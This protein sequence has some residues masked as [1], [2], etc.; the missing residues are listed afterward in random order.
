VLV[1]AGSVMLPG[2]GHLVTGSRRV[3]LLYLVPTLVA[4]AALAAWVLSA[5]IYGVA[6]ALVAPGVL[7]LLGAANILAATP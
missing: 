1:A 4:L 5:G 2:L 7:T 6:A 3:A